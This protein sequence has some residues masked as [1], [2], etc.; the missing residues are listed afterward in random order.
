MIREGHPPRQELM[1]K[2][3]LLLERKDPEFTLG[4]MI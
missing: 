4:I 1:P 2:I 3:D